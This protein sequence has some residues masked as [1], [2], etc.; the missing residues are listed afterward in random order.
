MPK[1]MLP[2]GYK[3][4]G[5]EVMLNPWMAAGGAAEAG[6]EG[7]LGVTNEF[8]PWRGA[9]N[10]AQM[11]RSALN[12]LKGAFGMAVEEP[13]FE[14]LVPELGEPP[15]NGLK[16]ALGGAVGASRGGALPLPPKP[17]GFSGLPR[18]P[19]PGGVVEGVLERAG[20]AQGAGQ[21]VSPGESRLM[22]HY[23]QL[24]GR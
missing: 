11:G 14:R 5:S 24:F 1:M 3:G 7:A 6:L 18:P 22:Q 17:P 4:D 10:L 23:S 12:G 19:I 16:G 21:F 9:K 2:P 15:A 13:A 20:D 8:V